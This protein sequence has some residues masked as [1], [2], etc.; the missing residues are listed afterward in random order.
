MVECAP[1][2]TEGFTSSV[3]NFTGL[4]AEERLLTPGFPEQAFVGYDYGQSLLYDSPYTFVYDNDTWGAQ[5]SLVE[6]QPCAIV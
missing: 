6:L 4:L 5:L 3:T 2:I 1:I